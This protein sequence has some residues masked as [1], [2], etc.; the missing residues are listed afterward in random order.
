MATNFRSWFDIWPGATRAGRPTRTRFKRVIEPTLPSYTP[1]VSDPSQRTRYRYEKTEEPIISPA[2]I[3]R[4][5]QEEFERQPIEYTKDPQTGNI[6]AKRSMARPEMPLEMTR[7][8]WRFKELFSQPGATGAQ[9]PGEPI[10]LAEAPSF[11]ELS[12]RTWPDRFPDLAPKPPEATTGDPLEFSWVLP[13]GAL[14]GP[15]FTRHEPPQ[16]ALERQLSYNTGITGAV[17]PESYRGNIRLNP[18]TFWPETS[19]RLPTTATGEYGMREPVFGGTVDFTTGEYRLPGAAGAQPSLGLPGLESMSLG[20]PYGRFQP[21]TKTPP[22]LQP[23]RRYT[24]GRRS[25]F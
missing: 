24:F 2:E 13:P 16:S 17:F 18:A 23:W 7:M 15:T 19:F 9:P 21:L 8:P 1:G 5:L 6:I 3:I 25:R 11:E 22:S 10:T 4:D 12:Y 20:E 14:S